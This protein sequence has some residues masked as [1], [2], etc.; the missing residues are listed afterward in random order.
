M[1]AQHGFQRIRFSASAG[2]GVERLD[3]AQQACPERDLIHLG[4]ETF[5]AFLL[6]LAGIFESEKLLWLMGG[7]DQVVR[8]ISSHFGT[9][10]E[11]HYGRL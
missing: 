8:R 7:S 2:L 11:T 4:E 5:A 1:N 9:C 3:Q 6:V 10:S